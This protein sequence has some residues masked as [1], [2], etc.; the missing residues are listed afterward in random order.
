MAK[1]TIILRGSGFRDEA[2]AVAAITPGHLVE[3]VNVAGVGKVQKHGT[4]GGTAE[5]AFAVEDELQGKEIGDDYAIN[6]LVQY[7]VVQ[8]GQIVN[9]LLADGES[10][11]IGSKLESNGD[12]ALK[13]VDA[14]ATVSDIGVGSVIGVALEAVDMSDSTGA[15]PTGRIAVRIL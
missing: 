11:V 7:D 4:A 9:A 8:R 13:V 2:L 1:K 14:D 15:D 3:L 10:A 12:G 5:K 6:T